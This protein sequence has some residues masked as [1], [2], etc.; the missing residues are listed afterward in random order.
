MSSF[1]EN[2]HHIRF[3]AGQ[4]FTTANNITN[5]FC[6]AH[7]PQS[8]PQSSSTPGDQNQWVTLSGGKHKLR[9]FEMCDINMLR[10]VSLH[11]HY[12]TPHTQSYKPISRPPSKPGWDERK[13]TVVMYD[14]ENKGDAEKIE[15]VGPGVETTL[16]S[17]NFFALSVD[18]PL[19]SVLAPYRIQR[20]AWLPQL[21]GLSRSTT[22][23]TLTYHDELMG[24][25]DILARHHKEPIV[26]TYLLYT[27]N[28]SC[29]GVQD[30]G[31]LQKLAV[32]LSENFQDWTF[33]LKTCSWQ[34]DIVS[35]ALS[36]KYNSPSFFRNHAQLR[37]RCHHNPPL[38][39]KAILQAIPD[40]LNLVS[41]IGCLVHVKQLTDLVHHN[42]LTFGTIID[43]T[44]PG[45]IGFLPLTTS[46]EWYYRSMNYDVDIRL[47]GSVPSLVSLAFMKKTDAEVNLRFSVRL[48]S[49]D[50]QNLRTAYL[51]QSFPI[52]NDT[53]SP[54]A[55]G[56]FI[57]EICFALTGTFTTQDLAN[58]HPP[59]YLHVPTL[60]TE[61]INN[62]SCLY[63][64]A[65]T[66]LLFYWSS[67]PSGRTVI[68]EEDWEQ[69]GIPKSR[70]MDRINV[71]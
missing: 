6:T 68:A 38:D 41:D 8:E 58:A 16:C 60:S 52:H 49:D 36:V 50:R 19:C 20:R 56:V 70:N 47:S 55:L 23:S 17:D 26:K 15:A 9:S 21:F 69:Y 42:V 34:Y 66:S 5:V 2:A 24:A 51:I 30:D 29:V 54:E 3:S 65:S 62:M 71:V 57:D 64:P 33:N 31:T 14:P 46:P 35:S 28:T 25:E 59:K 13:F 32:P 7:S 18:F 22:P 40:Y 11:V 53:T 27:H 45:I 12:W 63:W 43:H 39:S 61:W 44:R 4:S 10:E 48:A 37:L 67:D 1:F